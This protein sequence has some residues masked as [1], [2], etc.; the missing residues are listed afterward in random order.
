[1]T[2][3]F[4][5]RAPRPEARLIETYPFPDGTALLHQAGRCGQ[6]RWSC[7]CEAFQQLSA[8][9]QEIWC[10]HITRAAALRSIERLMRRRA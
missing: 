10:E 2:I 4:R 9:Q 5:L 3:Q 7:D 8:R 6:V 1:M